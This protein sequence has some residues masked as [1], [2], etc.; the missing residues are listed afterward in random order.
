MRLLPDARHSLLIFF[1][2]F[3]PSLQ[4]AGCA[5]HVRYYTYPGPPRPAD[6]VAIV[7]LHHN[8][9]LIGLNGMKMTVSAQDFDVDPGLSAFDIMY[10]ETTDIYSTPG[11]TYPIRTRIDSGRA[12]AKYKVKAGYIYYFYPTFPTDQHWKLE[13]EEFSGPDELASFR[14]GLLSDIQSGRTIR[15][16]ANEHF[17]AKE[18]QGLKVADDDRWR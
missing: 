13:M 2:L 6:A 14:P 18:V 11:D 16:R 17:R 5:P 4:I 10:L 8:L 1:L 9:T 3:L 12:I 15:N 7:I